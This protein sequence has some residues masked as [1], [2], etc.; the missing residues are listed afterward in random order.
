MSIAI[1]SVTEK[2]VPFQ[3]GTT[4]IFAIHSPA[5][6]FMTSG[7]WKSVAGHRYDFELDAVKSGEGQWSYYFMKAKSVK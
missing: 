6:T 4:V 2:G 3:A 1:E 5:K 7:D